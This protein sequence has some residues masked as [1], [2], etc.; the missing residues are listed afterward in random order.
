[1]EPVKR[2]GDPHLLAARPIRPARSGRFELDDEF[3]EVNRAQ[4]SLGVNCGFC[5]HCVGKAQLVGRSYSIRKESSFL[6]PR[7]RVDARGTVWVARFAG[8]R[9]GAGNI[10]ETAIDAPDNAG[11]HEPLERFV[12][13][14]S[15][16]QIEEV[17]GLAQSLNVPP[18]RLIEFEGFCTSRVGAVQVE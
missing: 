10:V 15:C 17:V 3:V 12:N 2:L 1:M 9:V 7:A 6:P 11:Q 8:Q 13:G 5:R 18:G 14:R 4:P 16:A